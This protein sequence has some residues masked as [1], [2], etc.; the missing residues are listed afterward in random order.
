MNS[1]LR[2]SLILSVLLA[3]GTFCFP[4]TDPKN[5][6]QPPTAELAKFDPFL[7]KYEVSGEFG[8]LPWTVLT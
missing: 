2:T 3:V 5:V 4:Q 7:G 8:N 6:P 1:S